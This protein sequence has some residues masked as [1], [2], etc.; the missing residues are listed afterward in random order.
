MIV[1]VMVF[2]NDHL[3]PRKRK[4]ACMTHEFKQSLAV[5]LSVEDIKQPP[6]YRSILRVYLLDPLVFSAH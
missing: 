5:R 3:T 6:E 2:L 4:L 1:F